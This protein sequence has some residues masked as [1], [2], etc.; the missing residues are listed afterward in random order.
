[1]SFIYKNPTSATQLTGTDSVG[2]SSVIGTNFSV[3]QTGGYMEVYNISDLNFTIPEGE[4]GLIE[5]TGNTVPI[6]Y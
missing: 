1:M 6:R 4:T 3:L 2:R 5:F